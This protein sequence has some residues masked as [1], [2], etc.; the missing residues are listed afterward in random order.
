MGFTRL[1]MRR[2]YNVTAVNTQRHDIDGKALGEKNL[3]CKFEAFLI[4]MSSISASS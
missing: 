4:S 2:D 1:S 3:K